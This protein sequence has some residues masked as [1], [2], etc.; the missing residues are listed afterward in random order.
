MGTALYPQLRVFHGFFKVRDFGLDGFEGV[1]GRKG[2]QFGRT[3]DFQQGTPGL[4][5]PSQ[6]KESPEK[7]KNLCS[8][9]RIGGSRFKLFDSANRFLKCNG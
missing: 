9:I 3:R 8:E 4:P 6:E 5:E 7:I 1:R 2:R